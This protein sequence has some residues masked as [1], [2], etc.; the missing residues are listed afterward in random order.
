MTDQPDGAAPV[1]DERRSP[2]CFQTHEALAVIRGNFS[3]AKLTTA[4]AIY[5]SLT[6]AA[7]RAGGAEARNGFPATRAAIAEAAGISVDTLDRYVVTFAKVGL[8]EARRRTVDGVNLPNVWVLLDPAPVPPVAAPVRPGGSRTR[9]AQGP[10]KKAKAEGEPTVPSGVGAPDTVDPE[11]PPSLVHVDGRN[12]AL[13]A[14]AEL[15]GVDEDSPRYGLAVTG[16][17]G[18][19]G[20]VGIRHLFWK[21]IHRW[22][23]E[24]DELDRLA[25]LYE[26]PEQFALALERGIKRKAVLYRERM[27]GATMTPT[28][29]RDWWLD[30]E[31]QPARRDGG[32][33]PDEIE[34]FTG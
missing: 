1:Q 12:V 26:D 29:L 6:E 4:L 32:L 18:S 9:A 24:H 30:L 19:R 34:Q 31:N 2:F 3:G 21:E 27:P 7:N 13:D 11:K 10:R 15:C 28:A 5:L 17:N 33:T 25:T 20:Q 16:L 22:A 14:L 8:V 23:V